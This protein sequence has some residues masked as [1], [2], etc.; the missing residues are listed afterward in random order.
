M[1]L[2]KKEII[3]F[4]LFIGVIFIVIFWA[5]LLTPVQNQLKANQL[6]F[7]TLYQQDLDNQAIINSVTSLIDGKKNLE[8]EI[9]T[10][11]QSLLPF[12]NTEIVTEHLVDILQ[13]NGLKFVTSINALHPES[14][15]QPVVYPDGSVGNVST[16][17]LQVHFTISGTDGLTEGGIP[18]AGYDQF[19]S[20][21][22][23]IEDEDPD[24]IRITS[25]SMTDT[26]KGYQ[27]FDIYIDVYAF[28][29]PNPVAPYDTAQPYVNWY[30]P[31]ANLG[32]LVGIPYALV[33]EPSAGFK[34]FASYGDS[35]GSTSVVS[36]EET[37]PTQ[38]T[39]IPT[40][41]LE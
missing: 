19:I 30:R 24:S 36:P 20:A 21:V 33:I 8:A 34:P 11:E 31:D 28:N 23:D 17:L 7:K 14:S 12:V 2:Q 40:E 6:E 41:T 3:I 15:I 38:E 29:I 37:Q 13:R 27:T 32:G 25:I 1:K 35:A 18:Y 39:E 26:N 9:G 16:S 22:K 10:I 5:F 4:S